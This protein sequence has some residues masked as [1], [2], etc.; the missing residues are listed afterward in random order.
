VYISGY[1]EVWQREQP[2]QSVVTLEPLLDST[3]DTKTAAKKADA[4]NAAVCATLAAA[5]RKV[6]PAAQIA[7]MPTPSGYIQLD[8]S[9][10]TLSGGFARSGGVIEATGAGRAVREQRI[11]VA[12]RYD[13]FIEGSFGRPVDVSIDGRQVA[14]AAY[15]ES[16]P[17]G[18]I[19]ITSRWLSAGVHRFEITRG[20]ISLHAGNGDGVDPTNR[21][22]G[23]LLLVPAGSS[24][25][26]LRYAS[27]GALSSLCRASRP[28]RWI[29]IARPRS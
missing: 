19:E 1:Y 5:A 24:V 16:Y 21:T 9:N 13:F 20:G 4:H 22:I 3:G 26:A 12:G 11:P 8:D 27:V 14:S 10:L 29:E 28:P 23:P 6:G 15:Q 25:P 7:Y 17:A 18:W 2:A